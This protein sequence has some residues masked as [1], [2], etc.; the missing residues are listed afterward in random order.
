M[1]NNVALEVENFLQ[2]LS[3]FEVFVFASI[4]SCDSS[5]WVVRKKLVEQNEAVLCNHGEA[6]PEIVQWLMSELNL[7][8]ER[9]KENK[10]FL[11]LFFT[12]L[13]S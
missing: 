6:L 1:Q 13:L 12:L 11:R 3:Y 4:F 7:K 2:F 10:S 8:R 9:E 5:L